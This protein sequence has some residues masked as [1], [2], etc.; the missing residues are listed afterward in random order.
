[1]ITGLLVIGGTLVAFW[2]IRTHLQYLRIVKSIDHIAGPRVFF[3]AA[4]VPSILSPRSP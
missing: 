3:S 1:V 4:T 2:A